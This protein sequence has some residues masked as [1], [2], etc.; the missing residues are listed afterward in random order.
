MEFLYGLFAIALVFGCYL[1]F[2]DDE[3]SGGMPVFII[4]FF[5]ILF[6]LALFFG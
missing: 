4:A 2:G 6:F 3:T 5:V 1:L